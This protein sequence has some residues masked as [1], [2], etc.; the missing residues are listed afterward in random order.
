MSD[1]QPSSPSQASS[2]GGSALSWE[3]VSLSPLEV[4]ALQYESE[5]QELEDAFVPVKQNKHGV[6]MDPSSG[7]AS[8]RI[9]ISALS[10]HGIGES[11]AQ[12]PMLGSGDA[13]PQ[14]FVSSS[15]TPASACEKSTKKHLRTSLAQLQ[16]G[17]VQWKENIA[18]E[19]AKTQQFTIKFAV[20]CSAGVIADV[21]LGEA[22]LTSA[23]LLDQRVHEQSIQLRSATVANSTSTSV[24][25]TLRFIISFEY[26][27]KARHEDRIAALKQ[28]KRQNDE[29]IEAFRKNA[30]AIN[31]SEKHPAAFGSHAARA[32]LHI[33]GNR[34]RIDAHH[35]AAV[36]RTPI[37][38]KSRVVTPFGRGVVVSFRSE[39]KMYVVQLD[40]DP[41]AKKGNLAYI[42]AEDVAEEPNEPHLKMY[43][44][45]S[46]P[47]GDG[48]VVEIRPQDDVI[49]VKTAFA[50]MYMHRKDVKLPEKSIDQMSNK[51]FIEEAV[52]L[53][54]K[55]NE[56][57]R[58]NELEEAI[59][60]YLRALAFLQRVDQDMAT[61]KDKATILQ[62]MIRCHLNIGTCKLKMD[63]FIDAEIACT[64]ALSI[65]TVLAENRQG[66]VVTWMGR[67]GLSDHVMF[68]EWPSKARFRR[69]KAC[70]KLG[71]YV[72]AKNDLAIA[73]RLNPKDKACRTLLDQVSKLINKQKSEEKKAWGGIFENAPPAEAPARK[74]TED[75]S[76][77]TRKSKE[78]REKEKLKAVR[79]DSQD[80]WYL[81]TKALAAASLVTAGVAALAMV[82]MKSQK[83]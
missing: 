69:A 45:V 35:P 20:N 29:Y 30:A 14:L 61:H 64:N 50:N 43:M 2:S 81:S 8:G 79:A 48:E 73:V 24:V 52:T 44:K 58:G 78:Q 76:I 66:N 39:T 36:S 5:L 25:G 47:Y 53:T 54:E 37:P 26:N 6:D 34:F 60:S 31:A 65:L 18:Y 21:T 80:P 19:G 15:I 82:A 32:E 72:D 59:F 68:E 13:Q 56:Q 28:K 67:L 77:F 46:T 41:S 10:V 27:A 63:A 1:V 33:P 70:M 38:D 9:I 12:H 22:E 7:K 71:K 75:F 49:V 51:D 74:N 62:T 40:K 4:L 17:A 57:F 11:V 55:G 23:S 42:R 83:S 16:D 3:N